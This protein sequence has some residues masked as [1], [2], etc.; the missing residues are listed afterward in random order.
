MAAAAPRTCA[1]HPGCSS[2]VRVDPAGRRR[3]RYGRAPV[4]SIA[5]R[6]PKV[7]A[8]AACT[9]RLHA[10][11]ACFLRR[12]LGALHSD[13]RPTAMDMPVPGTSP[14]TAAED[15]RTG[16]GKEA[17][18]RA[19]L[20]NLFYMQG[21]FPALATKRDYYLALAYV[22]RDRLLQRWV[23][24]AAAYTKQR[25]RTVAYLSAEFLIGPH[26]GNNL[27]NLGIYDAGAA[28]DRRAGPGL[29]R[30]A[31]AGGGAGAGQRRARAAGRVLPRFAGHAADPHAGLR[32]PLRVRHLRAGDR[33]RLAGGAHR[34]VAALRHALGHRAAGV[35]GG[36]EVR[37]AHRALHA[38]S[39]ADCACAGCP[40]A[41]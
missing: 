7:V 38:T 25:S 17:L 23:S 8:T 10:R 20:D 22:V 1:P 13:L 14:E 4:A 41:W 40:S 30:A 32:H 35:G 27:I 11:S 6:Y 29:R 24:T 18:K 12:H 36:G 31:A 19:F 21:K 26:L 9:R 2:M 16:L 33:R 37:R 28:G 39:R 5:Q 3:R 34:Q 15:E